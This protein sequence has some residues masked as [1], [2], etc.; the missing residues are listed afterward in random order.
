M[1]F[2][3]KQFIDFESHKIF[4]DRAFQRKACWE[5]K[6]CREFILSANKGR[7]P[8]PIIVADVSSGL[9]YSQAEDDAVSTEQYEK[10]VMFRKDWISLDG[11]NRVEA[12]KRLFSDG[13]EITGVF[14][15]AD[16]CSVGVKNKKFSALPLRLQDA[17]KDCTISVTVMKN[18]LY[19]E[20]HD[21]FVN[22][23]SGEPLNSQEKRNAINTP[24]SSIIRDHAD[25][26]QISEMFSKMS[27]STAS[28]FKRSIDAEWVA[29]MYICTLQDYETSAHSTD[30]DSF[31]KIGKGKFF[32]DVP[33]YSR[34][35]RSRFSKIINLLANV[36]NNYKPPKNSLS[37]Q[38]FWGMLL[39]CEHIIDNNLEISD[40][41]SLASLIVE[42]NTK[43]S[44]E[45]SI[46]FS[47]DMTKAEKLG[48]K[49][50][51]KA[52]YYFYIRG[53]CKDK[54]QR[55]HRR[56]ALIPAVTSLDK[57]KDLLDLSEEEVA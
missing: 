48:D 46:Q 47:S 44:V 10:I 42:I 43:L 33:Q 18:C 24:I 11:Q 12:F 15:D 2:K 51:S 56:K 7:A 35:A 25:R 21:I 37:Q 16:G 54:N 5:D 8:Y 31:Y 34:A 30:I 19:S 52:S 28:W 22:I 50:P 20:L 38:A 26:V 14:I 36:V 17:L 3:A 29:M 9:S 49:L 4:I 23:N 13:L 39:V 41:Q 27:M 45:S 32:K 57:F 1:D 53:V 40:Y 55:S 6:T